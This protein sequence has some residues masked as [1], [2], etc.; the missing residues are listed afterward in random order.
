MTYYPET[1]PFIIMWTLVNIWWNCPVDLI[2]S[3]YTIWSQ[4]QSCTQ[5]C[6]T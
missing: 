2:V 3:F 6:S 5:C 4:L 1:R